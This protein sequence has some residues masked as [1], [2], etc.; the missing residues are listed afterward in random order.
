[1]NLGNDKA[2]WLLFVIPAILMPAYL[3]CFYKKASALKALASI[4]M[5]KQINNAVSLKRQMLK[6]LLLI[7]VFAAIVAAL[8]EPRWNPKPLEVKSQGRDVVILLDTSRSMLAEDI[9]PTR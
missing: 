6:A 9:K 5:L 7:G 1:M 8:T 2:L 3:W 4:E